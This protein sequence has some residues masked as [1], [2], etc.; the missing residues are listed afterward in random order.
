MC[1]YTGSDTYPLPTWLCAETCSSN[2][3]LEGTPDPEHP[4]FPDTSMYMSRKPKTHV[5]SHLRY[6]Q[7]GDVIS[8]PSRETLV[9]RRG[10]TRQTDVKKSKAAARARTYSSTTQ[11]AL[12]KYPKTITALASL[13]AVTGLGGIAL[14]SYLSRRKPL[15]SMNMQAVPEAFQRAVHTHL[16][17]NVKTRS[18]Q[19]KKRIV[20]YNNPLFQV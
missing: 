11:L 8:V 13:A 7:E 3:P 14:K 17:H 10:H 18:N 6:S 2:A 15:V 16:P 5:R 20:L 9:G 12:Q 1:N 4:R 19:A